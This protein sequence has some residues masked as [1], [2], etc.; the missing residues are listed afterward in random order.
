VEFKLATDLGTIF[1]EEELVASVAG[2][3][4]LECYGIVAMGQKR[5]TD[6][7]VE[8][9]KKDNPTKGIKV[10]QNDGRAV[11][12][13]SIIVEYGV[14]MSAVANSVIDTVKYHVEKTTGVLVDRVNVSIVGIRT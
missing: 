7:I 14:S 11:I 12:N 4:C 3:C 1:I 5:A 9:F 6:G 8:M 10:T 13:L 2:L